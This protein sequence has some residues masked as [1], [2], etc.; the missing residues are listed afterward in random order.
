MTISAAGVARVSY[1]GNDVTT[2]FTTP[3]FVADSDIKAIL[4]TDATGA[5]TAWAL[6]T[7][8]T[9][10][11]GSG[12]TGTLTALVAPA[13]GTTLVIYIDP[14]ISQE[15]D[16]V[17]GDPLDVNVEIE[18][19]LDKLTLI[20][21][22]QTDLVERSLRLSEGETGITASEMLLPI[23]RASKYLG[24]DANKKPI[25]T[26]GTTDATVHSAFIA[27]LHDD[28]DAA[29]A[30]ATLGAAADAA[31]VHLTGT[32]TIPGDKTLS[33][34]NTYSGNSNITGD[35]DVNGAELLDGQA[36]VAAA[37]GATVTG[38]VPRGYLAG[39]K[40]SNNGTDATN[41]IDIAVGEA[42]D[43]THVVRMK[44]TSALTKRL[45][46][47]WA[48]G[49]NQ[50]GLD[51]GVEANSTW[52]HL[53]LIRKDSDGS[54]DA[55][56]STSATAPTMPG[57]YTYKRRIGSV[58]NDSGGNLK[59]FTQ[60]GDRFMWNTYTTDASSEAIG[61]TAI[62]YTLTVP[63]G[64]E[65]E[66]LYRAQIGT[67]SVLFTSPSH[68]SDQA[69]TGALSLSVGLAGEFRTLTNTS[70]Q[71]RARGSAGG[72]SLNL[73]THGWNDFRGQNA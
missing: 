16:L 70:A 13:T 34:N 57:G 35:V 28:P 25:A 27:T 42:T 24:F 22:R 47:V 31:V 18:Q 19:P 63:T 60:T 32:E 3:V 33:G 41:D 10:T 59:A 51:T 5:E 36:I 29:T 2:A 6:T 37:G 58:Y 39:L 8:Y 12:A 40:L 45:D 46:A 26:A 21:R 61:T 49:T 20:V 67:I 73:Y 66:A 11:G 53:W 72:G 1:A 52:Y 56:F 23:D 71:I 62:L 17:N 48:A 68:E 50:G 7:N 54:I 30:R 9:L 4:V 69:A 38:W 14:T 15:V 44:L 55:L 64:V 65:V 43:S